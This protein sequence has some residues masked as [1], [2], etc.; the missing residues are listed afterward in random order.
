[1]SSCTVS[2]MGYCVSPGH[3]GTA[4]DEHASHGQAAESVHQMALFE[5]R[6]V[7]V[8]QIADGSLGKLHAT[9]LHLFVFLSARPQG[10]VAKKQ[11][12]SP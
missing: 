6:C 11:T 10:T 12:F 3:T 4:H 9:I 7:P 2:D 1:M 8:D 5:H